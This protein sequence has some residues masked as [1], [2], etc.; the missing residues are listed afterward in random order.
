MAPVASTD[1]RSVVVWFNAAEELLGT[2]LDVV[3]YEPAHESVWS[4][5]LVTV[6]LET[7]SQLDSLLKHQV[8]RVP[9][10]ANDPKIPDY[11]QLFGQHLTAKNWVLFWGEA[12]ERLKPYEQ[13]AGLPSYDRNSYAG[14]EL[15]WWV[16]YNKVKHNRIA[17]RREATLKNAVLAMGGLF[18]AILYCDSCRAAVAAS[19]WL[20][21]SQQ[22]PVTLLDDHLSPEPARYVVAESKFYSYPVSWTR[23]RIWKNWLWAGP[24]SDR[25]CSWFNEQSE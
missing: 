6:L 9:G 8:G 10:A 11:F 24:A 15:P 7:C 2:V 1:L 3:P 19:G 20:Q 14:H 12:P 13:W 16:A 18:L 23:Q 17:N 5:K 4:P 21:S 25:F 22:N